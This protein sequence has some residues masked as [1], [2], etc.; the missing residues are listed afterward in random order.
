MNGRGSEPVAGRT[1]AV[2]LLAELERAGLRLRA[3]G[4]RLLVHP[5]R[6]LTDAWRSMIARNKAALLDALRGQEAEPSADLLEVLASIGPADSILAALAPEDIEDW[7]RGELPREALEALART[8]PAAR[9]ETPG[10]PVTCDTCAHY[11]PTSERLGRCALDPP[12]RAGGPAG[13]WGATCHDCPAWAK[14][15]TER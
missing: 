3:D 11:R 14:K 2:A 8:L 15:E 4:D 5:A 1:D 12:P 7:R 10:A 9:P 13:L 6:R